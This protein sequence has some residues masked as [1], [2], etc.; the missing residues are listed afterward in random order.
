MTDFTLADLGWSAVFQSQLDLE[1]IETARPAR[2]AA[3]QRDRAV[4]LM[5]EGPET[6]TFPGHLSAGDVAVGDWVLLEPDTARIARLL[7]RATEIARKAAG[8]A[9]RRQLIAA[10]VDTLGI[11]TAASAEFSAPRI[12]RYLVIA[13]N[14]GGQPLVILTKA[15]LADPSPYLDALRDVSRDC[16]VVTVDARSPEAAKEVAAWTGRGRTLALVGSSG[17]GKTTLTNALTGRAEAT[18]SVREDD[19][20]GRHTTT[21]RALRPILGGGWIVDTPG[22]REVGLVEAGDGIGEVFADIEALAEGCRFRDCSH[23]GEP[24]CA[25]AA[26]IETGTLDP[27]RLDRWRRLV[28][29]DARASETVAEA[30]ARDK[31]FG[32][33]VRRI[34]AERKRRDGPGR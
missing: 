26:A 29:E 23:T 1:D 16:P 34:V 11:V 20:R 13:A 15:D 25:V 32:K 21:F 10:N 30:R 22:M 8:E 9:A 3:I 31:R 7:D 6:V 12:E 2:V 18:A 19:Q 24:G 4:V 5:P 28:A 14:A 17:V 33:V 27:A